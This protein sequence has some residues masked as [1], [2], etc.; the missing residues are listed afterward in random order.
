LFEE[1]SHE[2]QEAFRSGVVAGA[3]GI[4][5]VDEDFSNPSKSSGEFVAAPVGVEEGENV[6]ADNW[7][8]AQSPLIKVR[9]AE[10]VT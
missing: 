5:P 1:T 9:L 7:V 2:E 4:S 10:G 8:K 6:N 3:I